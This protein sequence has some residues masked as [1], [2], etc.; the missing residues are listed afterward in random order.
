MKKLF[1][2]L[3]AILTL[4]SSVVVFATTKDTSFLQEK[5]MNKEEIIKKYINNL[6]GKTF[7]LNASDFDQPYNIGYQMDEKDTSGQLSMDDAEKKG[8]FSKDNI[9]KKGDVQSAIKK[10]KDKIIEVFGD[11]A[12]QDVQYIEESIQSPEGIEKCFDLRSGTEI[13]EEKCIELGKEY[14]KSICQKESIDFDSYY[15]YLSGYSTP[16]NENYENIFIKYNPECPAGRKYVDAYSTKCIHL[17]F[18]GKEKENDYGDFRF[19]IAEKNNIWVLIDG[20]RYS[21]PI[22]APV[23]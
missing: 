10:Q 6:S 9:T 13:S 14:W 20:I 4:V 15:S 3:V 23:D 8:F 12:F 16:F 7:D 18:N 19:I 5:K 21:E 17:K 1:I 11:N 2:I 22:E